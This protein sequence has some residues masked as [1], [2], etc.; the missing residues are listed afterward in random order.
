M[1]VDRIQGCCKVVSRACK[2]V[3]WGQAVLTKPIRLL[4]HQ[5]DMSPLNR[6]LIGNLLRKAQ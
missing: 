3:K 4:D 1:K 2:K 6:W 5:A